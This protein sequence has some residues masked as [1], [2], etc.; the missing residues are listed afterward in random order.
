[1]GPAV[2]PSDSLDSLTSATLNLI[3]ES[4]HYRLTSRLWLPKA[5]KD[6]FA[7][8]SQASNLQILTPP[9]LNFTILT[10][11]P[12]E[13]RVG[14]LI[15]YRIKIHGLPIQWQTQISAWQP[16]Y[17]F[18]DRQL[19]G[20]Y[21]FW[22]HQHRF[23]PCDHG[24]RCLDDVRYWPIGGSLIHRLFVRHDIVQ[25][26]AYRQEMLQRL[27]ASPPTKSEPSP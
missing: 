12:I 24:T 7:F 23:E 14:T 10:P 1:M 22:D 25:I 4:G 19:K 17:F 26:F 9:W 13:M 2:N 20:P 21:R 16:P 8:F 15:D 5:M 27:F 3:R 6:V 18:A 11:E